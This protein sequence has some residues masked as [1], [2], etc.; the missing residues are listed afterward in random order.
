MCWEEGRGSFVACAK[1]SPH[2][3][4]NT[5]TTVEIEK[6]RSKDEIKKPSLAQGE[7]ARQAGLGCVARLT[8]GTAVSFLTGTR[9]QCSTP[10]LD[11]G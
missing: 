7:L 4:F 8:W 6:W 5:K 2:A 9:F 1:T 11:Y 3:G 10:R